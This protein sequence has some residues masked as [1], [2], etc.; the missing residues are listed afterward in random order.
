MNPIL[1]QDAGGVA[2]SVA[3]NVNQVWSGVQFAA[4]EQEEVSWEPHQEVV[5]TCEQQNKLARPLQ[6]EMLGKQQEKGTWEPQEERVVTFEHQ[7]LVARE[8]GEI[9]GEQQEEVPGDQQEVSD[10]ENGNGDPAPEKIWEAEDRSALPA[11]FGGSV[12]LGFP[13]S[14]L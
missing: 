2:V 14:D 1:R 12:H 8:Q 5:V 13:T 3:K 7:K 11:I 6:E 4:R 10:G 9:V